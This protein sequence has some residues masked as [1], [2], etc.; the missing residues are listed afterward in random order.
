M[1]RQPKLDP[2]SIRAERLARQGLVEPLRSRRGLPGLIRAL[3]P[4]ATGPY[5]RPGSPPRLA[6]RTA[7][8]DATALDRLRRERAL[9]KGRFRAGGVGY[10][11]A[12]DLELY[13]NAFCKPL[14]APSS[15]QAEVLDVVRRAGPLTPKQIKDETGLLNKQIM[16]AL[17]RLQTAFLVYEEQ[18]DDDWERPWYGFESEWP[19]VRLDAARVE[20]SRTEVV[21]RFLRAC[22]FATPEQLRDWTQLPTRALRPLLRSLESDGRVVTHKVD[23]LGEGFCRAEDRILP[24][25]APPSGLFVLHKGDFL[26]RAHESDLQR[27]FGKS[28]ILQYLLIDG[29]LRGAIR[30]RWGFKPYDVK[31]IALDLSPA[32]SKRWRGEILAAVADAYPEPRHRI[33]RYAGKALRV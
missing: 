18:L 15:I 32:A 23:G 25:A 26:V 27:R 21:L 12:D 16:P 19:H 17:H 3:Q 2:A 30:G 1:P 29:E 10:V 33:L 5:A 8:D 28:E 7:F 6:H 24:A 22:V 31:D 14:G 11:L 20:P 9:V 13:A 4:L